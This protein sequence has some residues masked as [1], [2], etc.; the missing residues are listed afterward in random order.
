MTVSLS[1][2]NIGHSGTLTN[3]PNN[4]FKRDFATRGIFTMRWF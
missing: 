4:L 1:Y 2:A 3:L